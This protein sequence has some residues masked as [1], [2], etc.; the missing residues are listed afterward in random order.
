MTLSEFDYYLKKNVHPD[1][2]VFKAKESYQT[3]AVLFRGVYQFA[4]GGNGI[5]QEKNEAYGLDHPSGR[6]IRH[7]TL[8]EAIAMA[9]NIVAE[10]N[11]GGVNYRAAMG[12][13][14]FS[15]ANLEKELPDFRVPLA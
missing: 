9:K 1:F 3:A 2:T 6:F 11:K 8:P 15:D 12:L 7:R 13:G 10:M 4:I 14:E 5:Y